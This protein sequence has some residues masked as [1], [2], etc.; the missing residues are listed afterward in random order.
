MSRQYEVVVIESFRT[1]YLVTAD[2][3]EEARE[4]IEQ[5][6]QSYKQTFSEYYDLDRI[7]SITEDV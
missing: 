1:G 3:E 6:E 2:S 4:K 7:E 5:P